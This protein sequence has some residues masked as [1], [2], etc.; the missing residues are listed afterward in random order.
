MPV[1]TIDDRVALIVVDLQRATVGLPTISP[2]QTVVENAVLL[3]SEFRTR[4]LPVVLVNV[5][6]G[7]RG[8]T[9][10]GSPT[11]PFPDEW[12]E[13]APE[14]AA[15]TSSVRITKHGWGAFTGTDL[16]ERL[17][18]L[19]V[20]QVVVVGIATSMGVESTAREA[21]ALGYNVTQTPDA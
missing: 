9:E 19:G 4:N 20:T 21:Y 18:P 13:L 1:S 11:G 16:H 8:R 2:A 10:A 12:T 14:L 5:A 15:D 7:S 17:Q 3:A 6:G